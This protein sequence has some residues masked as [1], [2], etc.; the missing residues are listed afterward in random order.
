MRITFA[1]I[2]LLALTTAA[3]RSQES[4]R[5]AT[6][7]MTERTASGAADGA[8]THT[9]P[10][11]RQYDSLVKAG[12]PQAVFAGGCFWCMETAFEGVPGVIAA[13][14]GYTG[15]TMPNPT[16]EDVSTG[17]T[18][19]TE[20]VT[21]FYDSTR[22]SYDALLEIYWH[23][24]DPLTKDRQFCDAGTQYR[25]AIFYRNAIQRERAVTTKDS[26]AAL[27]RFAEPLVT[28]IVPASTF[29]PAEEYHQDFYR[30]EPERYESYREACRRD[31]RLKQ[32]WG[33]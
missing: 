24:I 16:Y 11:G 19:H 1:A 29:T 22:T 4:G 30:K 2:V 10:T 17:R 9:T 18:G 8:V 15:G 33:K 14:S 26:I 31:Q 28:E 32:L 12:V 21:V 27:R 20:S 25:S 23:N 13:I 7:A 3:C 5:A 6:E